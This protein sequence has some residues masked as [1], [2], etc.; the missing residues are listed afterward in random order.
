VLYL[1]ELRARVQAL[2]GFEMTKS[3]KTRKQELVRDAIYDAAMDLFARKGFNETTVDEIVEAAGIS[4]RS[5][6]RYFPTKSDVLA[7]DIAGH[8]DALVSAVETSP[9]E[10]SG[11]EI[12][13]RAAEAGIQYAMSKPRTRQIIEIS[14]Q[15]IP[16]RQ[17]HRAALVDVENRVSEAFAARAKNANK[18]NLDSRMLT[19]MTLMIV[20]LTL[21]SWFTGEA[22]DS[23]MAM[24]TV[25]VRL[26]RLFCESGGDAA[27][28][29]MK[30]RQPKR[31]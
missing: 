18:H 17:A 19:V 8:G 25:I 28:S 22:K 27:G 6:F 20:D 7:Y 30:T 26:N 3:L 11:L 9:K 2:D 10:L 1:A 14:A 24:R 21:T 29:V 23:E 4:Q 13:R 31:R 15:N 12:V 16:A 5:F